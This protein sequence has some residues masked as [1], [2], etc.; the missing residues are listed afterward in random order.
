[1]KAEGEHSNIKNVREYRRGNQKWTIGETSNIGHK[2][3]KNK[4]KA[5]QYTCRTPLF[6]NKHK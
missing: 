2:T 6:T 3:K 4:T 5:R 1:M